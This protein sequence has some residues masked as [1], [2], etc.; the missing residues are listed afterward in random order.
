VQA[1]NAFQGS[2]A[3]HLLSPGLGGLVM[4]AWM[5]GLLA[6]GFALTTRRD[7]A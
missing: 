7:V 6:I 3:D 1:Q 2:T 4:L 5:A